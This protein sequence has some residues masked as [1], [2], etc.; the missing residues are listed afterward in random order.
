LFSNANNWQGNVAPT[1]GQALDFPS[2]VTNTA[3]VID[4]NITTGTVQVDSNYTFSSQSGTNFGIT[5]GSSL[6]GTVGE[7]TFN[8]P[9]T[10]TQ[11]TPIESN[12]ADLL[13]FNGVIS[14][15]GAGYGIIKVGNGELELAGSGETYTGETTGQGGTIIDTAPLAGPIGIHT[16]TTYYGS[17][18]IQAINS[19]DGIISP[20]T[21]NV[22]TNTAAPATL[23]LA[24]GVSYDSPSDATW[25]YEL[26]GTTNSSKVVVNGGPI[27]LGNTTLST[28][29]IGGYT[30]ADGDVITLIK[31]NTGTA[32][33]GTFNNLPQGSMITLGGIPFTLSYT[34]GTSGKDVTLSAP[35]SVTPPPN[36]NPDVTAHTTFTSTHGYTTALSVTAS[37]TSSGGTA[38]LTYTWSTVHAPSGAKKITY[39]VN[40][41]N[42]ASNTV[43]RYYKD[44]TYVLQCVVTDK[45]GSTATVDTTV[46]VG[47]KVTAIKLEPHGAVIAPGKKEQFTA[48]AL[49]QFGHPMRTAQT[50]VWSL[51]VAGGT[52]TQAGLFTAG[53][54]KEKVSIEAKDGT[55]AA[56]VGATVS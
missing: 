7:Q 4:S 56:I 6:T 17:N 8:C 33:S 30:P 21:F 44:G 13:Q 16:G 14:D 37:D 40:G 22:S 23:T 5:L 34:G 25:I 38:G 36:T 35:G 1:S 32:V 28:N 39:T 12:D 18:S 10:L 55:L 41:T 31:N 53:T 20:A 29:L 49:D 51:P 45:S 27:V 43:A 46:V 19:A 52:I 9:I 15:G 3:V 2:G 11:S 50:F 47:Q 48:A 26:G 54:K 24:N 42:A